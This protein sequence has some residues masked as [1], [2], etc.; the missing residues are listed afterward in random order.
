MPRADGITGG[1]DTGCGCGCGTMNAGD[2]HSSCS[3]GC[4][5]NEPKPRDQEIAEL[6][7]LRQSID[8]RLQE[9]AT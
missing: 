1:V 3:C 6:T 2:T 4:S 5:S 8:Q 7:A 9:L